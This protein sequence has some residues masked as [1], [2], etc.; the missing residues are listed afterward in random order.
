MIQKS[1]IPARALKYS[2]CENII[3]FTQKTRTYTAHNKENKQ[4]LGFWVDGGLVT[5]TDTR[6]CD[7][8]LVVEND[9]C[10]LIELKGTSV[11]EACEQ[12]RITLEYFKETYQMQKFVGRIVVSRFNSHK[13]QSEKYRLLERKLKMIQKSYALTKKALDI[14][15]GK[16][17]D[18][19]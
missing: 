16:T 13:I 15:E 3:S 4:I 5:S 9:L 12:L 2:H 17:P 7:C 19:I 18:V 14:S 6:K 10:Y 11:D 8:A 1:D